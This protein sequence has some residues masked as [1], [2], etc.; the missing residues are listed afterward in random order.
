VFIT[1]GVA[2]ELAAALAAHVKPVLPIRKEG[3]IRLRAVVSTPRP[4]GKNW[5][6]ASA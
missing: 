2:G 4:N 3:V 1:L 5:K 6:P